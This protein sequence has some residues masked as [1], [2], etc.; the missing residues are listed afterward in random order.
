MH[1]QGVAKGHK[2][3]ECRDLANRVIVPPGLPIAV[4]VGRSV[5][6][7]AAVG[8]RRRN[9]WVSTTAFSSFA[10]GM[11]VRGCGAGP[12]GFE[13]STGQL[14]C[15]PRCRARRGHPPP[16]TL[17]R[18]SSRPCGHPVTR[19]I[20]D[21]RLVSVS[22]Q[23][24]DPTPLPRAALPAARRRHFLVDGHIII[25]F[26]KREGQGEASRGIATCLIVLQFL[27]PC[28]DPDLFGL[29]GGPDRGTVLH[30]DAKC[31]LRV[32]FR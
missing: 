13:F 25:I 6:C 12:I 4:G 18:P 23:S 21:R 29:G 9:L 7:E 20:A 11:V 26:P 3:P 22:V 32:E 1:S 14:F 2:V 5:F 24:P 19:N 31:G 16:S 17:S 15:S 27:V 30:I 28:R 10:V 8:G